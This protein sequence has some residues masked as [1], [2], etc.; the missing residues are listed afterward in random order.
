MTD[1]A[2]VTTPA[3]VVETEVKES[4]RAIVDRLINEARLTVAQDPASPLALA[5]LSWDT[6]LNAALDKAVEIA[7]QLK[8]KGGPSAAEVKKMVAESTNPEVVERREKL[9][10][11]DEMRKALLAQMHELVGAGTPEVD[12]EERDAL[13][14]TYKAN[15]EVLAKA[16]PAL[17]SMLAMQNSPDG[18][19]LINAIKEAIPNLTGAGA[20]GGAG[21]T[22][23]SKTRFASIVAVKAD[24]SSA[25]EYGTMSKLAFKGE[26]KEEVSDLYEL[27]HGAGGNTTTPATF[28]LSNG[29]TVT[30]TP[31][32][33]A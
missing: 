8:P 7:E 1:T 15:R 2:A 20:S 16:C 21:G 14:E 29:W 5:V 33:A 18:V 27:F 11:L 31:K 25:G 4:P 30:A 32:N 23:T 22:G 19:T 13:K 10:K 6:S 9:A 12:K 3:A 24:G 17:E 28:T 26:V